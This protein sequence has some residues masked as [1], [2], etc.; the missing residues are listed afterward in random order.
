MTSAQDRRVALLSQKGALCDDCVSKTA[1]VHPRQQVNQI[2]RWLAQSGRISRSA[3]ECASCH[4]R[5][6]VNVS[7]CQ[8]S[9]EPPKDESAGKRPWSS[10]PMEILQHGI[11][12]LNK[13]SDTNRRLAMLSIDNSVE[14]MIKTYLGLPQRVT[15]VRLSRKEYEEVSESFP[16]LLDAIEKHAQDKMKGFDISEMEWYHRLRNELYHQGNGLTVEREKVLAYAEIGKGL[17]RQLFGHGIS[18]AGVELPRRDLTLPYRPV[19]GR[20]QASLQDSN[21]AWLLTNDGGK[22]RY[23]VAVVN[24]K[25]SCSL[26]TF[27]SHNGK[28]LR[29]R[30]ARGDYQDAFQDVLRD[31]KQLQ[32]LHQPNLE[33]DCREQL[34]GEVFDELKRQAE[35]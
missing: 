9:Q 22:E 4:S 6:F 34:P 24:A 27:D 26:R 29:K 21:K 8:L 20:A 18:S 10:G 16:R 5:K 11:N 12:L 28:F 33:R 31:A 25:G 32:L 35:L 17:F 1:E 15:G 14:L 7:V 3:G 30:Y 23:F 2:C 19:S 13:D